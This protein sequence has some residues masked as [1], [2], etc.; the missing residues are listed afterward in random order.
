[1]CC[2][3]CYCPKCQGIQLILLGVLV[4]LNIYVLEWSWWLFLGV[5]L[6][7]AGFL[8]VSYPM[9]PCNRDRKAASVQAS[10]PKR[11]ARKKR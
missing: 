4:L 8:R 6:V 2:S 7:L 1:M 3:D 10:A 11:R 9:C 5:M